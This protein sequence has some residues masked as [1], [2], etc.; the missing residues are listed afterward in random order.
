MYSFCLSFC[1]VFWQPA[2]V[3]V[4]RSPWWL[5]SLPVWR[6]YV[7]C[8]TVMITWWWT[9]TG[10][11][12]STARCG[13]RNLPSRR[14][15][16]IISLSWQTIA[17]ITDSGQ[18]LPERHQAVPCVNAMKSLIHFS[19]SLT[20]FVTSWISQRVEL[21]VLPSTKLLLAGRTAALRTVRSPK[22]TS[23]LWVT[24]AKRT[25]FLVPFPSPGGS[26]R[27]FDGYAMN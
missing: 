20:G 11:S 21:F 8:T 6:T 12:A 27:V 25:K 23:P 16:S 17:P 13:M 24:H 9:S 3:P 4:K 22:P 15:S 2:C 10:T 26:S 7:F 14:S 18:T 1:F 5:Q 19:F